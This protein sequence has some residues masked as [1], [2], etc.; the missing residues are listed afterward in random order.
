[1]LD[2]TG[3]VRNSHSGSVEVIAEG[4]AEGIETFIHKLNKGPQSAFVTD[5][6]L[7]WQEPTGEFKKFSVKLSV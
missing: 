3:W 2:I 4:S 1:M 7:T 5:F 6:K